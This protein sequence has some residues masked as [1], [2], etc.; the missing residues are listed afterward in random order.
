MDKKVLIITYYWP[1]AGGPG[2]QRWLKFVKYLPQYGIKPIVYIPKKPNYPIYDYSL[3]SDLSLSPETL[4]QPIIEISNFLPKFGSIDS[5]RSGNVSVPNKQSLF[6]KILFFFRGNLFIPDMKIF[7]KKKSINFLHDYLSRNKID[8]VIT[9]GPPHSLH[10]IGLGL[11]RKMNIKWIADFRDPW[12]NLNYLNRF[13]L[14]PFVKKQHKIMRN[15]VL[16]Q[17]DSVIVTSEKL[18]KLYKKIT[19]NVYKI[20]NGFD[21]EYA[22][23]NSNSKFII[24]HIGSLYNER[25]PLLLWDILEELCSKVKRFKDNFQLNLIG[26]TSE[27]IKHLL[28]DRN[29]NSNIKYIDYVPNNKAIKHMFFS[30]ALLMVESNE[31]ESSYAIPAKLFDYMG[32]NRPIIAIGPENSEVK[33]ILSET[34]SGK[35][36]SHQDSLSLKS[37]ILDLYKAFE[38]GSISTNSKDVDKYSRKNLTRSLSALI[39]EVILKK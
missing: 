33:D 25:N 34:K 5:I 39:N 22:D 23:I 37:Y 38:N 8:V 21:Y 2:V 28:R 26:N 3:N 4:E 16:C 24:S 36:F 20:T 9:T 13:H 18:K 35:Y 11:K 31:I 29:F 6:Q 12:V 14:L 15:S 1:P 30:E 19:P 32:S 7:W 27:K 17:A 10:L